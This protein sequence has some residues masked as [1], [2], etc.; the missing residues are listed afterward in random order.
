MES[1][2]V[3]YNIFTTIIADA[4]SRRVADIQRRCLDYYQMNHAGK[5]GF[6]D[7]PE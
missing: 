1:L 2:E 5:V 6:Q 3:L 7:L 4:L